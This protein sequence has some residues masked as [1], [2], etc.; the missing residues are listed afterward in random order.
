MYNILFLG[1]FEGRAWDGSITDENHIADALEQLGHEVMRVQRCAYPQPAKQKYDFTLI[2]KWDG[3]GDI[4]NLPK[5]IL[6]WCF[7]YMGDE[8]WHK[9]LIEQSD[10]YLGKEINKKGMYEKLGTPFYWL[11]QDFAPE[12]MNKYDGEVEKKYDMVFTGTYLPQAGFRNELLKTIDDEF[13]LHIFSANPWPGFKNAHPA[14]LDK[15][16]P[17]LIAETKINISCDWMIED[18]YWSDRLA[19][20]MCCGGFVLNKYI[21]MQEITFKNYPVYFDTIEEC[22][23][24]ID[25]SLKVDQRLFLD[26]FINSYEYAQENLKTINRVQDLITIYENNK[27]PQVQKEI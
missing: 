8:D 19:Q 26:K 10:L 5:P 7:D 3:Y 1:N 6:Y 20:I 14:I 17:K 16:Y 2:A 24:K 23:E 22:L 18:G 11:S 13:D 4:S 27:L 21:P 12:F 9:K 25:E 15:D